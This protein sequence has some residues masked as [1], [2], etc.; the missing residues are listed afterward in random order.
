[1]KNSLLRISKI[2]KLSMTDK[3]LEQYYNNLRQH[4]LSLPFDEKAIE[5][6]ENN[7]R[8]FTIFFNL[9]A[10]IKRVKI[11]NEELI[12]NEKGLIFVSNHIG[13]YDQ[14][15]INR[16][17]LKHGYTPHYLVNDKVT[18]FFFRWNFVFKHVGVVVVNQDSLKSWQWAEEEIIKYLLYGKSVF[19]FPEGTRRGEN[20]IGDFK[21]GVAQ[22]AQ[23]SGAKIVTMA[24]KNFE[25]FL[26]GNPIICLGKVIEFDKQEE[27]AEATERLKTAVLNA[28]SEIVKY[29]EKIKNEH[30]NRH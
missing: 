8:I 18:K 13:S 4:Y 24:I 29:E 22:I 9:L 6:S 19:I 16:L 2:K 21:T 1:M 23:K 5:K 30:R 15:Y 26:T 20:N 12:P 27:G 17:L 11:L 14:F 25:K 28:Y 7:F 3:E 10:I